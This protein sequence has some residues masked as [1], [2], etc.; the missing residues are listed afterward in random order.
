MRHPGARGFACSST[1]EVN[2]LLTGEILD[3][4]LKVVRFDADGAMDTLGADVVVTV[5]A[6]IDNQHPVCSFRSNSL[7]EFL[8]LHPRHN[9]ILLILCE[10]CDAVAGIDDQSD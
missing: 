8:H 4:F 3:L 9:A 5:A 10:L 2:V 6:H 1:V 7:G